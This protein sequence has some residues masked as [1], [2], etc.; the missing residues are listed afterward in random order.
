MKVCDALKIDL[1]GLK[2]FEP[3]P[4]FNGFGRFVTS[5]FR[6]FKVL[7]D[8]EYTEQEDQNYVRNIFQEI[9]SYL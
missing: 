9:Q 6:Q 7:E 5:V 1:K 3:D 8:E 2:N 4:K